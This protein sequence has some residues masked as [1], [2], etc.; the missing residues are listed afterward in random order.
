M[1]TRGHNMT[2][3]GSLKLAFLAGCLALLG[4]GLMLEK[5]E[6]RSLA[7]EERRQVSAMTFVSGTTTDDFLRRDGGLYDVSSLLPS[8]ASVKDCKT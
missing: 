8:W 6:I 7:T 2:R 1:K 4:Y 3:T 5:H